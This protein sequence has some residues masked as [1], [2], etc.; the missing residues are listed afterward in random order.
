MALSRL[1]RSA[2]RGMLVVTALTLC[3][4]RSPPRIWIALRRIASRR[5]SPPPIWRMAAMFLTPIALSAAP[6]AWWH[7][8]SIAIEINACHLICHMLISVPPIGIPAVIGTLRAYGHTVH[9][10]ATGCEACELDVHGE[11]EI[12]VTYH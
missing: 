4:R 2:I 10:L 12:E 5:R 11:R 8:L 1:W 3:R 9:G 6:R 7:P